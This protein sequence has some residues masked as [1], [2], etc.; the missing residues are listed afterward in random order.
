MDSTRAQDPRHA[1]FRAAAK[2]S[3]FSKTFH[4]YLW[5]ET[6]WRSKAQKIPSRFT[7]R[8]NDDI[9]FRGTQNKKGYQFSSPN[10]WVF[11]AVCCTKKSDKKCGHDMMRAAAHKCP[12]LFSFFLWRLVWRDSGKTWS[13][14][15]FMSLPRWH[16][17]LIHQGFMAKPQLVCRLACFFTPCLHELFFCRKWLGGSCYSPLSY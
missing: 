11:L 3:E 4:F 5:R 12:L 1:R 15:S 7:Y 14:L 13:S 8:N 2:T 10:C 16:I 6:S 17:Y 9:T